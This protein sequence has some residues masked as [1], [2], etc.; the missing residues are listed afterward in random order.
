MAK[1]KFC[2]FVT[3][4]QIVK[5]THH[6]NFCLYGTLPVCYINIINTLIYRGNT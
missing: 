1:F 3:I 2:D 4:H 6:Q 5:F